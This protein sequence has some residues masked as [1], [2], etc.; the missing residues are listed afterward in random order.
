MCLYRSNCTN[1]LENYLQ[2]KRIFKKEC[3]EKRKDYDNKTVLELI[4]KASNKNS[5][6]FW[7]LVK[8]MTT[9]HVIITPKSPISENN[10]FEH[11][12]QLYNNV[13][14]D[15][16]PSHNDLISLTTNEQIDDNLQSIFNMPISQG[17]VNKVVNKLKSSKACGNDGIGSEF[18]KVNSN[19]LPFSS[20]T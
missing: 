13:S 11:F 9:S 2:S 10:W 18:Y 14:A 16:E 19:S 3:S 20:F 15:N 4:E 8:S 6:S 7:H 5:K 12:K 1:D 17:E